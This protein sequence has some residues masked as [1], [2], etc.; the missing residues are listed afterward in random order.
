MESIPKPTVSLSLTV[1]ES[2]AALTFYANAFGAQELF[3]MPSPE[4]QAFAIPPRCNRPM[5]IFRSHGGLRWGLQESHSG[6]RRVAERTDG[7]LLGNA[8]G[9]PQGP[10]RLPLGLES[11]DRSGVPQ[12]T[13]KTGAGDFFIIADRRAGTAADGCRPSSM[14]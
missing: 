8:I 11:T 4:W 6:G 12:R 14:P 10:L 1:R 5:P 2:A 9:A 3:P 7:D 13:G